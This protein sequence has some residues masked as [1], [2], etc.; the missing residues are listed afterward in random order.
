MTLEEMLKL[1]AVKCGNRD[2]EEME[3]FATPYFGMKQSELEADPFLPWF[4]KKQATVQVVNGE[5]T[6]PVG[7]IK[8]DPSVGVWRSG[9]SGLVKLCMTSDVEALGTYGTQSGD[10]LAYTLGATKGALYPSQSSGSITLGYFSR[11]SK[12]TGNASSNLWTEYAPWYLLA[13]VGIEVAEDLEFMPGIKFFSEKKEAA[14]EMLFRLD[15]ERN[16]SGKVLR[17]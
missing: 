16:A 1:I 14:R 12:L 9:G 13:S 15:V 11:D 6:L 3:E 5:F 4:L 17:W 2:L 7:F 8:V 10:S